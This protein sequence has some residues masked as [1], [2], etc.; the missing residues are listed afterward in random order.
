M[1]EQHKKALAQG[2]QESSAIK[3]YLNAIESRKPGRPATKEALKDRLAKVEAKIDASNDPLKTV[4]L[5]QSKLDLERAISHASQRES[6][7]SLEAGFVKHAASYSER[8]GISYTAWREVG[9]PANVLR[10][11]GIPETRRR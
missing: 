3:A 1:S 7:E 9:V 8:K 2:R 6:V 10:S 5:V 4:D 11:A